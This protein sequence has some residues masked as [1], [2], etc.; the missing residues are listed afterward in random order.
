MMQNNQARRKK[1]K[2]QRQQ[3]QQQ[4]TKTALVDSNVS[5]ESNKKPPKDRSSY[6]FWSYRRRH[7]G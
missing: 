6:K 7:N 3:Q 2:R 5:A 4:E 1:K